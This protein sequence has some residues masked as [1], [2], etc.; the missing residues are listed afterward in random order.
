LDIRGLLELLLQV[1]RWLVNNADVLIESL[2]TSNHM[3]CTE[4]SMV[5]EAFL[6]RN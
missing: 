6:F 4:I 5:E 1:S 3:E 2:E